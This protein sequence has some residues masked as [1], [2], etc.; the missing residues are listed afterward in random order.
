MLSRVKVLLILLVAFGVGLGLTLVAV[1]TQ[2]AK[3]PA[4]EPVSSYAPV[5]IKEPFGTLMARMKAEKPKV[6]ARQ[7]KLLQ[8]RYDLSN[9]PAKGVT[10]TRGKPIQEGVRVRLPKG[11]TWERLAAMTPEAIKEKGLWP[12]GFLPLPHPNHQEGGM[13]FPKFHIAEIKRQ[14]GRDLTRFDLDYDLPDHFLPEYPP[15]I[16]GQGGHHHELLRTVQ[17]HP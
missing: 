14:E 11:M 8:M 6:M 12:A 17:R 5:V 10:M 1:T 16:L 4:K 7:M 13:V 2:G 9:R 3:Q 15:P